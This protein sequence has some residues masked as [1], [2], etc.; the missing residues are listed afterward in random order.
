M[1]MTDYLL[2]SQKLS[3]V[4]FG[5]NFHQKSHSLIISHTLTKSHKT[6]TAAPPSGEKSQRTTKLIL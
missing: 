4:F 1:T 2:A 3:H 6:G 5:N